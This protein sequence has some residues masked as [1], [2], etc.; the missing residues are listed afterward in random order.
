MHQTLLP[1]HPLFPLKNTDTL[2]HEHMQRER[3]R[4]ISTCVETDMITIG[5]EKQFADCV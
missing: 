5:S 2:N 4:E 3:E 1:R